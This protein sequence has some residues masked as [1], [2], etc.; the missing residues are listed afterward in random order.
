MGEEKD[1]SIIENK[2]LKVLNFESKDVGITL[3]AIIFSF[4]LTLLYTWPSIN[5]TWP[6]I[7]I[8]LL[9]AFISTLIILS[10]KIHKFKKMHK[11]TPQKIDFSNIHDLIIDFLSY[12]IP[13]KNIK[14]K[15]AKWTQ[16]DL[17]DRAKRIGEQ[18]KLAMDLVDNP[19]PAPDT[20][21]PYIK[22]IKDARKN[23][24]ATWSASAALW[25]D[26]MVIYYIIVMGIK[27]LIEYQHQHNGELRFSNNNDDKKQFF[28]EG[29]D[30]LDKI[31]KG[32]AITNFFSLRFLILNEDEYVTHNKHIDSVLQIHHHFHMHCIPLVKEYLERH[33]SPDERR[34]MSNFVQKINQSEKKYPDF[35][36]VDQNVWWYEDGKPRDNSGFLNDANHIIKILASKYSSVKY[37]KYSDDMVKAITVVK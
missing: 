18:I 36:I 31:S 3:V 23:T 26:P 27:N 2:D 6:S 33:L 28:E 13:I 5:E 17:E 14:M 9:V 1:Y 22:E 19:P 35:L 21:A 30:I 12:T 20:E 34:E 10:H 37:Q 11:Q 4:L 16:N 15:E 7:F 8:S 29:I 24:Y 25:R 32:V